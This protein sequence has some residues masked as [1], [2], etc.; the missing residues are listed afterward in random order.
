MNGKDRKLLGALVAPLAEVART[1]ETNLGRLLDGEIS[2]ESRA[3]CSSREIRKGRNPRGVFEKVPGSGEW[4]IRYN[5]SNGRYRREKAGSKS[6]AIKLVDKRRTEALQG[7]KL[8]ES[9][10]RATVSFGEIAKD[11]LVY[12][13]ANKRSYRHDS[14]RMETLLEWF[15]EYAAKTITARDIEHRFEQE[16][17]SPATV[18][19]YRALLSLTYRLAI[20]N[21]KVK[22]NPARLV[23]HRFEDNARIRFLS[24][25][26]ETKLRTAIA[27]VCP[28]HLAEL[29]LALHTGMRLSEQYGLRWRDVSFTRLMLTIPISKNGSPRHISINA[30]ALGALKALEKRANGSELVC[31]G[32]S[33]P[34]RWFDPAIKMAGLQGFTWHCLRHTFASRLVMAR[35]DIRT[36]QELMG[37]KTISMTVRY[38]HLSPSHTL[39]AVRRLDS[40]AEQSTDTTTDTKGL[41][42]AAV[43]PEMLQQV[44]Q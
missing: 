18:N 11:A 29:D 37:H 44:I 23:R 27:Q 13:K 42:Q 9:L 2:T 43:S 7:K 39:A 26:E 40:P 19:R 34:R 3:P 38:A 33:T 30:S 22:E 17:W 15:R 35:E 5:D 14:G 12:S 36:V 16:K 21:N 25:E 1:A 41:E 4:W 8:P 10:R 28:S 32:L 31:G 20:G 24:P 6:V